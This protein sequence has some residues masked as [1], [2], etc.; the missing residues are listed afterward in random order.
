MNYTMETYYNK[1]LHRMKKDNL[2]LCKE[3]EQLTNNNLYLKV[4]LNNANDILREDNIA[5]NYELSQLKSICNDLYEKNI[6][7]QVMMKKMSSD[8]CKMRNFQIQDYVA[9]QE[10]KLQIDKITNNTEEVACQMLEDFAVQNAV[11]FLSTV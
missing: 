10:L 8:I 6:S 5:L 11:A 7:T 2:M 9:S 4:N 3:K 1:M